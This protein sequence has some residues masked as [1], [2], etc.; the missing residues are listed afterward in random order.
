MK[1]KTKYLYRSHKF[2]LPVFFQYNYMSEREKYLKVVKEL[3]IQLPKKNILKTKELKEIVVKH[4]TVSNT[5]KIKKSQS[6]PDLKQNLVNKGK[7]TGFKMK[8]SLVKKPNFNIKK[9]IFPYVQKI[10][11]IGDIHGDLRGNKGIKVSRC[12]KSFC[13]KQHNRYQIQLGRVGILL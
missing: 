7:K 8:M 4:L 6:L 3:G 1:Y 12:Y 13:S 11:A 9:S 10:V 2:K 5:K